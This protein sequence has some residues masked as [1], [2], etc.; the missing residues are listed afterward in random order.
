MATAEYDH[1]AFYESVPVFEVKWTGDHA[2]HPTHD[3]VMNGVLVGEAQIFFEGNKG[4]IDGVPQ[5]KEEV[6]ASAGLLYLAYQA[7]AQHM[8]RIRPD[9]ESIED[10]NGIS[11]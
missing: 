11:I 5:E 3:L 9:V 10:P 1:Q 6:L 4:Y 8:R 7:M 2:G